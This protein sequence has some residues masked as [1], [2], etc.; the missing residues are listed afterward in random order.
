MS[1]GVDAEVERLARLLRC[2][3]RDLDFLR[4]FAAGELRGLRLAVSERMHEDHRTTYR[5]IAS[6]S[7]LLPAR[8]TGPLGERVLTARVSAGVVA[9]L[10]P[11][12]AA[13]MARR[14]SAAYVADVAT[15]LTAVRAEPV[16]ARMPV[17][18]VVA[19]ADHL[20]HAEEYTTMAEVVTAL[21][22][23]QVLAVV[24]RLDD[25]ATLVRVALRVTDPSALERLTRTLPEDRLRAMVRWARRRTRL[26]PE[27]VALLG[28]LPA[29][30]RKR[31]LGARTTS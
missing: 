8:V 24:E 6:A 1:A 13:A 29:E 25:A 3:P 22:E 16:L 17:D 2:A 23:E 20:W 7:R 11:D 27:L 14:M 21:D 30:Q 4:R 12:H 19:V 28:R 10:P 5:R 9:C 18:V 31:L 26:W 15:H